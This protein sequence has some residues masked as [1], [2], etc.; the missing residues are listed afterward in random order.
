MLEGTAFQSLQISDP[1]EILKGKGKKMV[2]LGKLEQI[3]KQS[4]P[5][6]SSPI[7]RI[8]EA[9]KAPRIMESNL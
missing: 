4:P 5:F 7:P 8:I 2:L 9:G 3:N 1:S 6:P